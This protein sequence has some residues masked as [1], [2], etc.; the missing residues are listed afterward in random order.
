V[1]SR[2]RPTDMVLM[3]AVPQDFGQS[4]LR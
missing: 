2:G 3:D 1:M 4:V